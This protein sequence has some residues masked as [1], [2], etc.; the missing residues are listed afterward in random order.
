M[1]I[2]AHTHI[3]EISFPVGKSRISSMPERTLLD[4]I[5][6]YSIDL[7]LVSSIEGAE[8]NS[9]NGAYTGRQAD[10]STDINAKGG[11]FC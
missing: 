7:V 8:F 3:G 5:E 11:G 4:A 1:I 10:T 6:K 9:D 2:D